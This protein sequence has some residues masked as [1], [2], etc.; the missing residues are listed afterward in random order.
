V[1]A[2]LDLIAAIAHAGLPPGHAGISAGP[3]VARDGD[4][5]G[6]TVNLAARLSGAAEAGIALATRDVVDAVG[7]DD[8]EASFEPVG[9]LA[10]KNVAQPV[11]AFRV[12]RAG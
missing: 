4:Y 11:A 3:L 9:E 1:L 8:T 12:E 5:F 10:L 6:H 2:T 7:R